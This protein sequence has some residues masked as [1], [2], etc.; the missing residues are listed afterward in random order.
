M[1]VPEF[2]ALLLNAAEEFAD[3]GYPRQAEVAARTAT[4]LEAGRIAPAPASLLL[5]ALVDMVEESL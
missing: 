1:T 4:E 5:S 3:L 2:V